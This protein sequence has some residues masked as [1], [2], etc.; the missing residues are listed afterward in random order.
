VRPFSLL[1][2]IA[3]IA[4]PKGQFRLINSSGKLLA[5]EKTFRL[6]SARGAILALRHIED[7]GVG[8]KLGS[9]VAID[10]RAVSCSNL[11]R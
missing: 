3:E 9:G 7:N 5:V 2:F 1:D 6:D 4:K 10:R 8:V 11:P